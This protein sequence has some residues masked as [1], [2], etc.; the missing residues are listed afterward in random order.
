MIRDR[1]RTLA[2]FMTLSALAVACG[3]SGTGTPAANAS[4]A[5][6]DASAG[7]SAAIIGN[8]GPAGSAA[9]QSAGGAIDKAGEKT[10]TAIQTA[11]RAMTKALTDPTLGDKA[12]GGVNKLAGKLSGVLGSADRRARSAALKAGLPTQRGTVKSL[13]STS[14]VL[15]FKIGEQSHT[16][17]YVLTPDTSVVDEVKAGELCTVTYMRDGD[18][19][20]AV[21]FQRFVPDEP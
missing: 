18:R 2:T 19:N 6:Q 15:E 1:I 4:S 13:D 21:A 7:N 3:G 9:A 16:V 12:A 11:D 10:G 17:R 8:G 5:P 14:L 20:I